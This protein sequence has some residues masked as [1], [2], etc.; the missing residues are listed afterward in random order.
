M[1]SKKKLIIII[2]VIY[3]VFLIGFN[4]SAEYKIEV[5]VPK[6]PSAGTETGLQDYIRYLYLFG[7][8]AVGILALGSLVVGGF[9]YMLS[10]T[11]ISKDN[12]KAYI[13]NALIGLA[14]GLAAYLILFTIN[15]DLISLRPPTLPAIIPSDVSNCEVEGDYCTF[16]ICCPGLVCD[17]SQTPDTCVAPS[18]SDCEPVGDFCTLDACCPGLVCDT[19]Q[20]PD[21]CVAPPS[22]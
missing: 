20:T 3:F 18:P 7:L 8:G 1:N 4:V 16:D 17:T 9:L 6:G 14:L 12:A 22:P 21:T 2:A 15:P 13:N 11:V 10:D 19:S 5:S